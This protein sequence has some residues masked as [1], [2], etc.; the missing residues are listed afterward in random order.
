MDI[1][2][3]HPYVKIEVLELNKHTDLDLDE[4]PRHCSLTTKKYSNPE[5]IVENKIAVRNNMTVCIDA[6]LGLYGIDFKDIEIY[7]DNEEI[8][9]SDEMISLIGKENLPFLLEISPMVVGD[10]IYLRSAGQFCV[11][12]TPNEKVYLPDSPYV[13]CETKMWIQ[14]D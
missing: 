6:I 12:V 4:L 3:K 10:T 13:Y 8:T 7:I 11:K 14:G 5:I 9:L 2:I 1:L